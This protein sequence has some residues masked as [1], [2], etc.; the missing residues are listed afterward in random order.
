MASHS[1][2]TDIMGDSLIPEGWTAHT[3][4]ICP[5]PDDARVNV[6]F[7]AGWETDSEPVSRFDWTHDGE[8]D[9]IIAYQVV[10]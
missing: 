10:T 5:L 8:P 6:M 7:R 2:G 3:G 1:R 9:D 4:G